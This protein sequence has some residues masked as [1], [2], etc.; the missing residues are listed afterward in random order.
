[1]EPLDLELGFFLAFILTICLS[2]A[3]VSSHYVFV[4]SLLFRKAGQYS[5]LFF[6]DLLLILLL[7]YILVITPI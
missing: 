5:F 7:C 2:T 6:D 4:V 1:M 3:I